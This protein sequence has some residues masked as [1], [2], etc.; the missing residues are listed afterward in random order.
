MDK[1]NMVCVYTHKHI[2]THTFIYNV[3]LFNHE[4]EENPAIYNTDGPWGTLL[5]E[6][7]QKETNPAW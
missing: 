1:E 5:S 4:E 2:F 6:I 3:I 7:I